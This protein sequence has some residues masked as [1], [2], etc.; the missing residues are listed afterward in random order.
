MKMEYLSV[1]ILGT[2]CYILWNEETMEAVIVDPGA[3]D[4]KVK[5]CIGENQL[6]P[7]AILLTHGHFDHMMGVTPLRADYPDIKVYICKD[8][9]CILED[10]RKNLS[11]SYTDPATPYADV[12]LEDQE[13]IRL[14]GKTFTFLQTPGHTA[15]S[16]CYYLEDEGI[17]LS[18]DT[19]FSYSMGRTDLPTGNALHM[20]ASLRR[21]MELPDAVKVFPGHSGPTTIERERKGNPYIR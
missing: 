9:V 6:K 7:V 20:Q 15:G 1:G 17:L 8:D 19:L 5:Q 4:R 11:A 16:G 18:G 21:L 10:P 14:I 13:K 12:L 2:N 3:Y